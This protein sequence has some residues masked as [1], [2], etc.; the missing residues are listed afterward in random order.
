MRK[1][2]N[3]IIL[4]AGMG[5]RMIPIT[6]EKPKG[7]VEVRGETMV[8][9]QIKQLL[10]AGVEKIYIVTGYLAEQFDFLQDKYAGVVSCIYNPNYES[11]NNIAS[12]YLVRQYLGDTYLL[13]A[14]N[15][16]PENIF[17]GQESERSWYCAVRSQTDKAEWGLQT[18]N[19][20][21]ILRVQK[22]AAA[23]ELYMYGAVFF[24]G[25]VVPAFCRLLE[26]E[27]ENPA[28]HS[29]LWEEVLLRHTAELEFYV[30]EES[31]QAVLE[32]ESLAE[33]RAFDE[34]YIEHSGS[35]I[36]QRIAEV[37]Q[38]KESEI[39]DIHEQKLGMTN[40]SFLFC[41]KGVRYVFRL[42]GKGSGAFI[43]RRNEYAVYTALKDKDITE[44]VVYFDPESGIKIAVYEEESRVLRWQQKEEVRRAL[45]TLKA[46]HTSGIRVD[47]VFYPAAEILAYERR[48]QGMPVSL[49]QDYETVRDSVLRIARFLEADFS[50]V[51][52][53]IDTVEENILVL[54]D[55]RI[56]LIDWEYAAMSD[57]MMDLSVFIISPGYAA[58]DLNTLAE[59]YFERQLS[60][61]EERKLYGYA[62]VCAFYWSLWAKY[63]EGQGYVFHED[64]ATKVYEY[65]K[66]YIKKLTEMGFFTGK[67]G[68]N[69]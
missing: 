38:V 11:K 63:K 62:A 50:P 1:V 58:A 60:L 28:H 39:T 37:F 2:R 16:Y 40:C 26:Q 31:E 18:D 67:E 65:A 14:D 9:R 41:V 10:A 46:V 52:C 53:H 35:L 48:C 22:Q 45:Q 5:S 17:R 3:A 36:L 27:Y 69:E 24:S 7:L 54:K 55:G 64:Y 15:Y 30:R 13:S 56:R 25:E 23:G 59:M 49:W 34:R 57:P 4:A 47:R 12:L 43:S 68:R 21:R 42:P 33:L 20:G 6:Y 51:L 61:P 66:I 8:E 44:R 29:W 19:S 32:L